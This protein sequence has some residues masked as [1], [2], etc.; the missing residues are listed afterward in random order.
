MDEVNSAVK[1]VASWTYLPSKMF[2]ILIPCV[3]MLFADKKCVDFVL[4]SKNIPEILN[5]WIGLLFLFIS[6]FYFTHWMVVILY[7]WIINP[8]RN[9]RKKKQPKINW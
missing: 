6:A 1:E 2:A 7:K 9:W 4:S 5:P 8:V 3:F